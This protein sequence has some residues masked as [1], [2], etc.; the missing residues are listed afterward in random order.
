MTSLRARIRFVYVIA[1][2]MQAYADQSVQYLTVPWPSLPN[3][4]YKCYLGRSITVYPFSGRRWPKNSWRRCVCEF[5]PTVRIT[6]YSTEK[7]IY[8]KLRPQLN[9]FESHGRKMY[10]IVQFTCDN[11]QCKVFPSLNVEV[12]LSLGLYLVFSKLFFFSGAAHSPPPRKKKRILGKHK[13]LPLCHVVQASLVFGLV[14]F[15]VV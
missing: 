12:P 5:A 8:S 10:G 15:G 4:L 11:S 1:P 6:Q 7:N 3:Q 9:C 13:L 2:Q 14:W